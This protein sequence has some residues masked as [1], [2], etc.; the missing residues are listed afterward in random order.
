MDMSSQRRATVS[1][2]AAEVVSYARTAA[3]AYISE[4]APAG[5]LFN[6]GGDEFERRYGERLDGFGVVRIEGR[7]RDVAAHGGHPLVL[8]CFECDRR[9]RHRGT[10]A[11]WWQERTGEPVPEFK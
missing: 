3:I 6:L 7:L 11:R 10:F 2:D 9:D 8:L 5:K 4:L 1:T